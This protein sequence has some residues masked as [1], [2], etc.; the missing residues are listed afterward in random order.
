VLA[1]ISTF[2][3]IGYKI[4]TYSEESQ[5]AELPR[6]GDG[7]RAFVS[8]E[9]H[10]ADFSG[11]SGADQF[12]QD[13][14]ND[15][16]IGGTWKAWLSTSS[17]DA[18]AR[19]QDSEYY[20]INGTDRLFFNRYDLEFN[21]LIRAINLDENR[22]PVNDDYVQTGTDNQGKNDALGNCADW[23]SSDSSQKTLG[24]TGSV[25]GWSHYDNN[26]GECG[27]SH[28]IYCF[29]VDKYPR[30]AD[31][32]GYL[33]D[34][35]CDDGDSN[36]HPGASE[37]CD[38]KDTDCVG[39]LPGT[40]ADYD[41]D[42][43]PICNNDCNDNMPSIYPGAPEQCNNLDDNCDG[44]IPSDELDS[45]SDGYSECSG[46]CN[47]HDSSVNPSVSENCDAKDNDCDGVIDENLSKPC[48]SNVGICSKGTETCSSG[49][50]GGCSGVSPQTE[51]CDGLDNDCNGQTDEG[52]KCSGGAQSCGSEVGGCR[53][54]TQWCENGYWG[55]CKG[56]INPRSETCDGVDNDCDGQTDEYLSK[57]CGTDI[58]ECTSGKTECQGGIWAECVGEVASSD[59]ICDEKDNNCDGTV[60]EGCGCAAGE[61][62][63]CGID[64]GE[65]T[66]GKQICTDGVW[67]DCEGS[68][69]P[70]EETCDEKDNDCN[71]EIDDGYVCIEE[72]VEEVIEEEKKQ[73][74]SFFESVK[75]VAIG[76]W[77]NVSSI[78]L[79]PIAF[80]VAVTLVFVAFLYRNYKKAR[81]ETLT[82]KFKESKGYGKKKK[83]TSENKKS[84]LG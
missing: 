20:R 84:P 7:L 49:K 38:G 58:G 1:S 64:A 73:G 44:N 41:G 62:R 34:V 78:N 68:I 51:V 50:W 56:A 72:E 19:I 18:L 45:D 70:E 37:I 69:K 76:I 27:E 35:D 65:C 25:Y 61:E 21:G 59:E 4:L 66:K 2:S 36:V 81:N 47:D 31:G 63:E 67:S 14:A 12:C 55:A 30:D 77:N 82:K 13:L 3:Y 23:N 33:E 83:V 79:I 6:T 71:G 10:N 9:K 8:S 43:Y 54:G 53:T 22:T 40:E 80:T 17:E 74:K 26:Y 46:D 39:G 11:I 24:Y 75:G 5:I 48:G 32:D 42:G 60:D 29:E 52:C 28:R 16:K 15:A 57:S